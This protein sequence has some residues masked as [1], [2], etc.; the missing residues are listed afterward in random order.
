MPP[1]DAISK[2]LDENHEDPTNNYRLSKDAHTEFVVYHGHLNE[3]KRMQ[4]RRNKDRKSVLSK[5]KGQV[6][7]LAAVN[8]A[9]HQAIEVQQLDSCEWSFEI[10]CEFMK[11]AITL[12]NFCIEQKFALGKLPTSSQ[13]P[14][15]S[16]ED[17]DQESFDYHRIKRLLELESPLTITKITQKH[18]QKRVENKYR[19]EEAESLMDDVVKLGLGHIN[20]E[21]YQAGKQNRMKKILKKRAL[22]DLT[23]D[24]DKENQ[25]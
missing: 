21:E 24:N 17:E 15:D 25:N 9:L 7:R 22:E 2:V 14:A 16:A 20:V 6:V 19:K 18:I 10:L 3:R 12:M 4:H 5:A 1:R 13:H 23:D 11:M 8:F